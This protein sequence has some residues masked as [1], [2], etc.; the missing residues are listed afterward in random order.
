MTLK[1][2]I[3]KDVFDRFGINVSRR[4]FDDILYK[5]RVGT[6]LGE[7]A[8][9]A[10]CHYD[11]FREFVFSMVT[12]FGCAGKNRYPDRKT[13]KQWLK[14]INREKGVKLDG[15]YEC[16]H[17]QGWH[18]TSKL[19]ETESQYFINIKKGA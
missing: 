1:E 7:R 16:E 18:L 14:R 6:P 5:Y 9:Y 2:K 17:C 11:D 8:G 3:S 4:E 19:V 15:V 10:S 12:P 13:A